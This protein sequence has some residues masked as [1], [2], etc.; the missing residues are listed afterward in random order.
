MIK[1]LQTLLCRKE[2]HWCLA[3]GGATC[4][5]PGLLNGKTKGKVLKAESGVFRPFPAA[6]SSS[7]IAG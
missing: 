7:V 5:L 1:K 4:G 6:F 3:F 2:L